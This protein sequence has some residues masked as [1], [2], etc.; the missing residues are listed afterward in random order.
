MSAVDKSFQLVMPM[1]DLDAWTE[2]FRVAE[3]PVQGDTADALEAMR[4]NEDNVDANM[5]GEMIATDP[6]MTLK[7]MAYAAGH[8]SSRLVT[9]TTT[10]TAAVIMMGISPFFN[11]FGPQATVED[12]L[13]HEPEAL[14]GLNQVINRGRRAATF[15]I[16]FAVHRMDHDAALIH[17]AALLHDFAELLLWCHAPTLALKIR[18]AQRADPTLRSGVVQRAVLNVE[19]TDLQQSLMKAWRLAE[20]LIRISDDRQ[21]Q[22]PSVRSVVLAVRLA[23]HTAYGWDNA[24]LPDD[25]RDIAALLNLS[26]EATLNLVRSIDH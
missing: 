5:I 2:H 19:L 3:I 9:D 13:G 10:V 25:I 21:A 12:H 22:H 14:D 1:R 23:R 6:L 26:H 4:A 17:Q 18:D 11:S 20:L 15:A 7:V 24:A 8:R 16:N